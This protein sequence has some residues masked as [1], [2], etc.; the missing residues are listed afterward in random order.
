M[1]F[2]DCRRVL[3][4]GLLAGWVLAH[5]HHDKPSEEEAQAPIDSILWIHMALQ[6]LVWGIMFP[7]GM[8][9]GL[10]KSK[11]HVPLQVRPIYHYIYSPSLMHK[12]RPPDSS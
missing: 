3:L 7:I 12:F 11:W 1:A 9:L 8:V 5:E 2:L 10:S 6:T 4:L